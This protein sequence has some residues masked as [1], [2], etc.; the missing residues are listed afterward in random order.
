MSFVTI[1]TLFVVIV[2]MYCNNLHSRCNMAPILR[3]LNFVARVS[4][5]VAIESRS[6]NKT[7]IR[8]NIQKDIAS[9]L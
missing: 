4:N 3:Q 6:H 7:T 5:F 1:N 2:A 8:G 9:T